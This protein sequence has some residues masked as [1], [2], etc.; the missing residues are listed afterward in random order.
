MRD[1]F[2]VK[3]YI[4]HYFYIE[5]CRFLNKKNE[6]AKL[7]NSAVVPRKKRHYFMKE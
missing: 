1:Y 3:V 2:E 5:N 4:K 7:V 6:M